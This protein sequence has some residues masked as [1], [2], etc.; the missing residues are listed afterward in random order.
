LLIHNSRSAVCSCAS[1]AA[2]F[3]ELDKWNREFAP[4]VTSSGCIGIYVAK[5][6]LYIE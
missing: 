3:Y 1:V 6:L 4:L 5:G 2:E